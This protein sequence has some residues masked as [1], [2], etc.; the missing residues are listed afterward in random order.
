M[1]F[2]SLKLAIS[3]LAPR[4][5]R[6]LSPR[7]ALST[8]RQLARSRSCCLEVARTAIKL[9]TGSQRAL[10]PT[11]RLI[12]DFVVI[13]PESLSAWFACFFELLTQSAAGVG[14]VGKPI[15]TKGTPV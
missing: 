13:T 10:L 6:G 5:A 12:I 11:V 14:N 8:S 2:T 9:R 3:A 7:A 15:A 1:G 4:T